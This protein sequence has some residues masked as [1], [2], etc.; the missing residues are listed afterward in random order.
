[1]QQIDRA[2]SFSSQ[3]PPR[4]IDNCLFARESKDIENIVLADFLPAK[5]DE[6]IEHRFRVAQTT[7]GSTRN[8]MRRR[9]CERDFLFSSDELQMFGDEVCRDTVK[10]KPL[11]TAQNGWQHFLRLGGR[12]NKFHMRGRFFE[13]L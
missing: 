5:C 13:S 6:L 8:S 11:A 1:M 4:Q 2:R 12:E 9:G 10:I 3:N 7:L